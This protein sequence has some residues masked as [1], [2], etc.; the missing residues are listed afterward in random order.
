MFLVKVAQRLERLV[1]VFACHFV[2]SDVQLAE[3]RLVEKAPG[4][5]IGGV[6][7][8]LGVAKQRKAVTQIVGAGLDVGD[9]LVQCLGELVAPELNLAHSGAK[10]GLG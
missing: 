5:L 1:Q 7:E 6:V 9:S 2:V 10:F 4:V 8:S 3:N